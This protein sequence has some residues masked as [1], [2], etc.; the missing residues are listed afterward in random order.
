M[1]N[2]APQLKI[3]GKIDLDAL[4]QSTRPKKKTK[5][6]KRKERE[7]KV[8][9]QRERKKRV[10]INNERVDIN[11]EVNKPSSAAAGQAGEQDQT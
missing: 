6:E 2:N 7:E 11:A 1:L 3:Q 5:E 8:Q 4:N 10:R 9:Q